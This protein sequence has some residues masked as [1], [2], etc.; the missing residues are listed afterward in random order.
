MALIKYKTDQGLGALSH[1]GLMKVLL[2]MRFFAG[3]AQVSKYHLTTMSLISM[4]IT[5][6]QLSY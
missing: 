6:Q 1:Y 5:T 3:H 2:I 4:V